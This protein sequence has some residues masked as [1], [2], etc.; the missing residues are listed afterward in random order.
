MLRKF[1][2]SDED[3][4]DEQKEIRIVS[5]NT[6]KCKILPPPMFLSENEKLKFLDI[7]DEDECIEDYYLHGE[8][9][10]IKIV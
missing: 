7:I 4:D 2:D 10:K 6:N 5:L 9:E 3:Y 8:I 1:A